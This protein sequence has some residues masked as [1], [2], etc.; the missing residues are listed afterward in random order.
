MKTCTFRSIAAAAS[1]AAAMAAPAF[2]ADATID[3]STC[4]KPEYPR[5]SLVNEEQGTV[6]LNFLVAPDG[7][8]TESKVEKSSGFKNLDKAAQ[9]ALS[10]CK[11]KTKVKEPTWTKLDY[12]WKLD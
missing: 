8:V 12:V 5:A 1:L 2:G 9:K 4:A 11:F 3:F 7:G 6:T 10:A